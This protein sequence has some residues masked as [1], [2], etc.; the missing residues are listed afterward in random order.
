MDVYRC[1]H[2]IMM[3][4]WQLVLKTNIGIWFT[5]CS[6]PDACV[7]APSCPALCDPWTEVCQAS[8]SM[9]FSRQ[10]YWH[11]LPFPT[12]GDRPNPGIK[13]H[14]RFLLWQVDSLPLSYLGSPI[15]GIHDRKYMHIHMTWLSQSVNLGVVFNSSHKYVLW[16]KH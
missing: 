7:R 8:L 14:L 5:F 9:D 15:R 4:T 6:E 2:F 11:G 16:K 3:K 1:F 13:A 12:S 10:E